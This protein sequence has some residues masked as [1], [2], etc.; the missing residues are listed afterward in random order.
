[1]TPGVPRL[2]LVTD[3]RAIGA[4]RTLAAVIEQALSA[5]PAIGASPGA[6]AVQL[7]EKDLGGAAL[8]ACGRELRVVTAAA[9]VGLYVNGRVDVALAIGADGVHLGSD[10]L[11]ADAVAAF[12]PE[13]GV[14]VSAHSP[15]EVAAAA[16]A[17]N[18]RFAVL[19]P[20]YDT[21]SKR[22]YGA[23]LGLA[24]LQAAASAAGAALPVLAIGGIEPDRVAECVGAGAF[25]VACIRA[26][27]T[28]PDP[29]QTVSEFFAGFSRS[30][31][32]VP[33]RT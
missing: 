15:A 6:V 9:G 28:S 4:G 12:A 22:R 21:P 17:P 23:P 32:E 33:R 13:L 8:A 2:Y 25:G 5:L 1:M 20:I 29:A 18:V 26:V 24:P 11:T 27:M 7:R 10:T 19:G 16:R 31:F 30:S 3:R 14:A